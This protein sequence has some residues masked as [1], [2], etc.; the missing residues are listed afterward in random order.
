LA[1]ADALIVAVGGQTYAAPQSAIREV[2]LV[3][4]TAVTALE[5]NE[6][7]RHHGGVLPLLRLTDLFGAPRPSGAFPALVVGEGVHAV[8]LAVDRVLGLR[9]IVVRRLSD[10]LVQA[11]GLAGATELGDGRAILI[12]DAAG[13]ARYSRTRRRLG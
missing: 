9:E 8:A 13:L 3:E 5:N 4:P 2:V 1:I 12:L 10:P 6:L 7:V 11:P